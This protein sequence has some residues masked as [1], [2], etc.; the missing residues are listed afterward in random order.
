MNVL[1]TLNCLMP[2]E[3]PSGF[4]RYGRS[5]RLCWLLCVTSDVRNARKWSRRWLMPPKIWKP[6]V[7]VRWLLHKGHRR[8]LRLFAES[9][10]AESYVFLI[11]NDAPIAGMDWREQIY[12]RHFFRR[13]SGLPARA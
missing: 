9:M 3:N 5:K 13:V 2:M 12:F 10:R 11:Q 6:M 7:C 4:Q 1:L 8:K